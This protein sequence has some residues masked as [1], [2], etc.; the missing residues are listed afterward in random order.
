MYTI[1]TLIPILTEFNYTKYEVKRTISD[2]AT[3]QYRSGV[4]EIHLNSRFMLIIKSTLV[5]MYGVR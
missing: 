1:E 3:F 4:K 2:V 5:T